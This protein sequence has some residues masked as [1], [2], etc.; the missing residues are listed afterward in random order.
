[1]IK[2]SMNSENFLKIYNE[3]DDFMR[4]K[5][6]KVDEE[7]PSEHNKLIVALFEKNKIYKKDKNSLIS[8]ARLRNAIVHNPKEKGIEAIA[9]PHDNVL[10][11]YKKIS[12]KIQNP[13]KALDTIAI[14]KDYIFKIEMEDRLLDVVKNMNEKIYTCAPVIEN[15]KV[16]GIF[17][18]N[19][20]F[21][22]MVEHEEFLIEK[23]AKIKEFEKFISIQNN[24]NEYFEF[25]SR[26]TLVIDVEE[27]FIKG[28]KN[29][30]RLGL[31]F[32]TESGKKTEKILGLISAWDVA[33]YN[34]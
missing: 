34:G 15:N 25:V 22:Y 20:I 4:K 14:K 24:K 9:E 3:L 11:E 28:L 33:G 26:N 21:S 32:I 16:I 6:N 18:E 7:F 17:S 2:N 30:K 5:L 1:M 8:F 29:N 10:A 12:N 13:P 31:V 23:D 19:V 27:M